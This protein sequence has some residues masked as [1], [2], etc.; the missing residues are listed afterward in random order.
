ML[1]IAL[2][3]IEVMFIFSAVITTI[4]FLNY[5]CLFVEEFT[6]LGLVLVLLLIIELATA[7]KPAPD[8][9]DLECGPLFIIELPLNFEHSPVLLNYDCCRI[10]F[11][12]VFFGFIQF[13]IVGVNHVFVTSFSL[14]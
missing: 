14:F 9:L 1:Q 3:G 7:D 4:I 12:S 8:S 10:L 11:V 13:L 5:F 6:L 2:S